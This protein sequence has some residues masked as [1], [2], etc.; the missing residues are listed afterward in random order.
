MKQKYCTRSLGLALALA[1]FSASGYA[2][3]A[4]VILAPTNA[5]ISIV[6]SEAPPAPVAAI[7]LSGMVIP[8]TAS[9]EWAEIKNHTYAA[10][11][12]FLAGLTRL[13]AR[14]DGQINALSANRTAQNASNRDF[15]ILQ[16]NSAR[17]Q[18]K[19]MGE[20]MNR[21]TPENWDR[22]KEQVAQAWARTQKFY[23]LGNTSTTS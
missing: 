12:E 19:N 18:F 5:A 22:L 17:V 21:A 13:A 16:M 20:A 23:L 3:D 10:R 8:E 11:S 6:I 14:V 9:A 4:P 15:A 1:V 2:A 7:E